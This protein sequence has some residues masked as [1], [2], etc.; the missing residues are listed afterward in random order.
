M[1]AE[2]S[3]Q[4]LLMEITVLL[5]AH[6]NR[7]RQVVERRKDRKDSDDEEYM[8]GRGNIKVAIGKEALMVSIREKQLVAMF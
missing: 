6:C 7:L 8:E 1:A 5:N 3:P 2:G 4:H